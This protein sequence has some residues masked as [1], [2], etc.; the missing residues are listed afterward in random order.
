M[1]LNRDP[2]NGKAPHPDLPARVQCLVPMLKY[3]GNLACFSV[4]AAP[5]GICFVSRQDL[6]ALLDSLPPPCTHLEMDI[7][8][9]DVCTLEGEKRG[10][11]HICPSVRRLLPQLVQLRLRTR[12]MCAAS[13]HTG[14]DDQDPLRVQ[15]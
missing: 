9:T 3:M 2:S 7:R 6:G 14:V 12:T 8:E 10:T 5:T 15:P 1:V 11:S 4:V 13:F